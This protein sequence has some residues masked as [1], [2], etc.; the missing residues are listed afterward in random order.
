[1]VGRDCRVKYGLIRNSTE[2]PGIQRFPAPA[3]KIVIGKPAQAAPDWITKGDWP[4][5]DPIRGRHG[6]GARRLLGNFPGMGGVPRKTQGPWRPWETF[7]RPRL[8]LG[9]AFLMSEGP[10]K[11]GQPIV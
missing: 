8:I 10:A 2:R 5:V 6:G 4:G 1:V 7:Q 9:E 3:G 11:P